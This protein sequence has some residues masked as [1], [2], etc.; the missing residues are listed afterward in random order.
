MSG[1]M[2]LVV[3]GGV[4]NMSMIPISYAMTAAE[5]LGFT[6]P[7]TTSEGWVARYGSG[8]VNQFVGAEMM[9][10]HWDITREEM[11]EFAVESHLRALRAREE[12]R[13]DSQIAPLNGLAHD[14]GPREPNW[15]K[16][17]SLPTHR[18]WAASPPPAPA[19]SPTAPRPSSWP[20]SRR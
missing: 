7:F 14:E 13:F 3:A 5:P 9:A 12:G 15:E 19:R 2:D 20:T 6:D 4:Q 8:E 16:I 1:T 11:E 10:S 18:R 17:R